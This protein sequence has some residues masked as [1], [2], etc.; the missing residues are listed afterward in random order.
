MGLGGDI[1][2][3]RAAEG[4]FLPIHN[5]A[6]IIMEG[7]GQDSDDHTVPLHRNLGGGMEDIPHHLA[8]HDAPFPVHLGQSDVIVGVELVEYGDTR[9]LSVLFR[10]EGQ[11]NLGVTVHEHLAD[12]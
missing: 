12:A 2:G 11:G 1:P 8:D 9:F 4:D 3:Q 7:I 10:S 6:E 5:D